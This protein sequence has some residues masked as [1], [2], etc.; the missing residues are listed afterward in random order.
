MSERNIG[1]LRHGLWDSFDDLGDGKISPFIA[2]GRAQLAREIMQ[3]IRL[4]CAI[5]AQY[6]I[7]EPAL[8]ELAR[9]KPAAEG[10]G[11]KASLPNG[12]SA[13]HIGSSPIH[14]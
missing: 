10:V 4:Q 2:A 13:K 3:S 14:A 8:L 1:A 7:Q 12:T 6:G 5:L 11:A 9:E